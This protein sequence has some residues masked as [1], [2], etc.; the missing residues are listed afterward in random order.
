MSRSSPIDLTSTDCNHSRISCESS[1]YA[2]KAGYR[3]PTL[4]QRQAATTTQG[5]IKKG[6]ESVDD[7][8]PAPLILP[9][10]E[11]AIDPSCPPQ[12]L[13]SWTQGKHRNEVTAERRTIYVAAPPHIGSA[14]SFMKA[15]TKPDLASGSVLGPPDISDL[16]DYLSAFYHGLPVKQLPPSTL[17][18]APWETTEKLKRKRTK[19]MEPSF[20]GLNTTTSCVRIRSRA[21]KD[22]LFL[23]QLNL[24]ERSRQ[25]GVARGLVQ[26]LEGFLEPSSLTCCCFLKWRHLHNNFACNLRNEKQAKGVLYQCLA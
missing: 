6:L 22:G 2:S 21:P 3:R 9:G 23:G 14:V 8:F 25:L 11:L 15:W 13:R 12:S 18:F 20:V 24:N 5:R 10:D 1:T 16:V 7:Q 19:I 4:Q 17:S 26:I